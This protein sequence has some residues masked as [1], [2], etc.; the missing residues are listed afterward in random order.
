MSSSCSS[1]HEDNCRYESVRRDDKVD[2][3][4]ADCVVH[5]LLANIRQAPQDVLLHRDKLRKLL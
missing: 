3:G 1:P 5:P 2:E 4:T